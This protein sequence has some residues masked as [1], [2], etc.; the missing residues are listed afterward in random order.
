MP[1][2]K[3]WIKLTFLP[4]TNIKLKI[5]QSKSLKR[6][7]FLTCP[8]ICK[9]PNYYNQIFN[10]SQL[11]SLVNTRQKKPP[12]FQT[13]LNDTSSGYT[14]RLSQSIEMN[15]LVS[16]LVGRVIFCLFFIFFF[17]FL[18]SFLPAFLPS[19]LP[20]FLPSFLPSSVLFARKSGCEFGKFTTQ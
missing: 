13:P 16:D 19:C 20:A 10:P 18:P 3:Y 2:R 15:S 1:N 6:K 14:E 8:I 7:N 12:K 9:L 4:K 17:V 5:F 11:K